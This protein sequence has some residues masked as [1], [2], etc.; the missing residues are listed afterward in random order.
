MALSIHLKRVQRNFAANVLGQVMNAVYQLISVPLFLHFWNKQLYGEWLVL[1]SIPSL[2]WSLEGGLAGVAG[3][4]M[5]LA[6][7]AG[8]WDLVNSVFQN[9]LLAQT[10]LSAVLLA[11][12]VAVVATFDLHDHLGFSLISGPDAAFVLVLLLGYMLA[13]FYMSLFRAAYR[14]SE[15]EARGIM[16]TNSWRL[17]DFLLTV[18]VVGSHGQPLLLAKALLG[19]ALFWGILVYI[20]VR[21]TCPRVEF[22]F[23]RA[24]GAQLKSVFI[25]GLPMMAGQAATAFFL[26]GYP[27]VINRVLGASSVATFATVRTVS[28]AVLL[29]IQVVVGSSAPEV[30]RSYGR[31]DWLTYLRLLK[32]ML[33]CALWGGALS[34]LGLTLA[35]PWVIAEWTS[36]RVVIGHAPLFLFAASV[37]LQGIWGVGGVVLV[38]SN[39]HHTFN[40]LY[41]LVTLGALVLAGFV[42]PIWG[43]SAVPGTMVLQDVIL[44]VLVVI[45]CKSKLSHI[46]LSDLRPVFT[47]GFYWEKLKSALAG[48]QK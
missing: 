4:R 24:S 11:T 40:Y 43:F 28:R 39:M 44:T 9:I 37:A 35:G 7:S 17:T 19:S 2:L 38:C 32:I 16:S 21:R 30:S 18:A 10:A 29:M 45:L 34:L 33:A 15:L 1:F 22:G 6:G 26:Q 36:G 42:L 13:G 20:D 23:A 5:T 31:Q 47:L 48:L 14:A 41:F 3:T 27:L 12:S 8:D 25:D 46:S